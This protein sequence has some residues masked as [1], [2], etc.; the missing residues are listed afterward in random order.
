MKKTALRKPRIKE[1]IVVEGRDDSAAVLSVVSADIIITNGFKI[2]K[3]TAK[4]IV[5]AAKAQGIIVFTD[6]D[7]AGENIRTRIEQLIFEAEKRVFEGDGSATDVKTPLEVDTLSNGALSNE[8]GQREEVFNYSQ[9]CSTGNDG[10]SQRVEKSEKNNSKNLLDS[11]SNFKKIPIKHARLM[12]EEALKGDNIGV[13][14]AS[15]ESILNALVQSGATFVD[16]SIENDVEGV[17][18]RAIQNQRLPLQ[19][20]KESDSGTFLS[21]HHLEEITPQFLVSIGCSS[22]GAKAIRKKI[23]RHFGV[24]YANNKQ[25]A[26][27]LTA[28]GVTPSEIKTFLS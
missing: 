28:R 24:G 7:Y 18:D 13:E 26:K 21:D 17:L 3:P 15:G 19:N 11:P 8:E 5:E 10:D 4:R 25:L 20:N 9:N 1:S 16:V 27:R 22:E 14:N 23:G 2:R 12:L 6:P